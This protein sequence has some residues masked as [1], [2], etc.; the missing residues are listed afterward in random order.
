MMVE[1]EWGNRRSVPDN[2]DNKDIIISHDHT[3]QDLIPTDQLSRT[4]YN[5]NSASTRVDE[6][7]DVT[8]L[9]DGPMFRSNGERID[10]KRKTNW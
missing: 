8:L 3:F 9:I 10:S 7:R 6:N 1:D 2:Y 4:G 5:F